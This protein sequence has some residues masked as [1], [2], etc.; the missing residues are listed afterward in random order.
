VQPAEAST[1]L[2]TDD[3]ERA[4]ETMFPEGFAIAL[5]ATVAAIV[6]ALMLA[7]FVANA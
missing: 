2:G 7:H 4:V 3:I 5:L 6:A 1:E